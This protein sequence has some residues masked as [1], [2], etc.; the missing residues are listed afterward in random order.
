M[1]DL[2]KRLEGP[3]HLSDVEAND[4]DYRCGV[5]RADVLDQVLMRVVEDRG[6]DLFAPDIPDRVAVE[7]AGPSRARILVDGKPATPWWDDRTR[8]EAGKRHWSFEP[9]AN[10][11]SAVR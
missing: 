2:V 11:P 5:L 7:H 3:E 8:V 4:F 6:W 10:E 9:E 1:T